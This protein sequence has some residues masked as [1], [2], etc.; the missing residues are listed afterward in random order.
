[1]R[2][3][4]T[5]GLL[6]TAA[7]MA[8]TATAAAK[9]PH[10]L[11]PLSMTPPLNPNF[12]WTCFETGGGATCQGTWEQSYANE[13]IDMECDGRPVYVTGTGSERMTRWHDAQLRATKTIVNLS[14]PADR[15][16]LS[17]TGDGPS[18]LVRGHWERH[19]RYGI[20]GDLASRVL[21]E[22]GAVYI[23]TA[24][25]RGVVVQDVGLVRFLPGQDFEGIA[26]MHGQHDLYSDFDA[27]EQAVCDVLT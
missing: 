5:I 16:T 12:T 9:S 3:M 17:P 18:L 23:A 6:A 22:L 27:V 26:E 19:Y 2:R 8:A 25:G 1:M 14:Y 20:P 10:E 11:D 13:P 7:V 4:R 15:L 21:T 24:P